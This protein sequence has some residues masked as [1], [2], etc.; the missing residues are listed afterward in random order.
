MSTRTHFQIQGT[1]QNGATYNLQS[2]I[3]DKTNHRGRACP[4]GHIRT[5]QTEANYNGHPTLQERTLIHY[6]RQNMK[7]TTKI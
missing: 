7:T 6:P 2:R 3:F 4:P 5:I 1:R